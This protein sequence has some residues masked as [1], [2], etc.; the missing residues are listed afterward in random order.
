[1]DMY[2]YRD[3]LQAHLLQAYPFLEGATA[4]EIDYPDRGL[5]FKFQEDNS[6]AHKGQIA[7]SWKEENGVPVLD[8]PANSPD[9][10][11][12]E[13]VW[14]YIEDRL[15]Q[16]KSSLRTPDDTWARTREI[17]DGIDRNFILNLYN[18]LPD[19]MRELKRE[20]GGPILY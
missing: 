19:R 7:T 13:N 12:I 8:W 1:M 17:W 20:K 18:T 9:L 14:A 5:F 16:I 11:L 15:S 10:S 6:P 2:K 3:T 4:M